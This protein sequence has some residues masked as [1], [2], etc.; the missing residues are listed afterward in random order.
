MLDLL[1]YLNNSL[2]II[3]FALVVT[4]YTRYP[5]SLRKIGDTRFESGSDVRTDGA[6][7]RPRTHT[8]DCRREG[9]QWRGRST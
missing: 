7:I 3:S 6:S 2:G 5:L 8:G 9:A 4:M 1:R